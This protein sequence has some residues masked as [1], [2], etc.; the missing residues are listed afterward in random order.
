VTSPSDD[1]PSQPVPFGPFVLDRRLAVG[2]TAEVFLARPKLGTQPAMRFVVKRLLD[3]RRETED[4]LALQHEAEL[5]QAVQHPNVV[6]VYGAGMVGDEPY[7]ALEY[8]EG[9]DLYRFLRRV[10]AEQRQLPAELGVYIARRVAFA[11]EAVHRAVDAQGRPLEIVHRDVTPSNVYLSVDGKVKLGDFGI[12]RVAQQAHG[13]VP[14]GALKGKFGYLA[15]EQIA[16]EPFDGRADLFALGAILGELLI[17]EPVFP[18]SG[19]LA[20]LL[21]I[22]EANLEPLYRARRRLQP[23]LFDICVR[24]LAREPER[25]FQSA[26]ELAEALAPF[27]TGGEAAQSESL[28]QWVSSLSD[29][30]RL[31]QKIQGQIRESVEKMRAV[32]IASGLPPVPTYTEPPPVSNLTGGPASGG[33]GVS[34]ASVVE[35]AASSVRTVDGRMLSSVTFARLVEMVATGELHGDDEVS[36]MGAPLKPLREIDTLARHLLPSTTATTGRLFEPGVPDYHVMLQDTSMLAV[37]ARMRNLRE[38]GGL[39]VELRDPSGLARRKEIY[40]RSG[41]LHHVASSEREELLGEYLVRRG[42]IDRKQLE[43][44]LLELSRTGGRLG[45]TLIAMEVVQAIDVF[46]AIR[47]QGRDRV[48]ALC[49][50]KRGSVAFYRGTQP[51]RVEFP[52][53]LDLA[54]PMMAGV[55]LSTRGRPSSMIPASGAMLTPGPRAEEASHKEERGTVPFSM[56]LVPTL[57]AQGLTIED[58]IRELTKERSQKTAN[59]RPVSPKEAYAALVVARLLGWVNYAAPAS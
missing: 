58:A 22:R 34:S 4:F 59:A 53:D 33:S 27:E 6:R 48:A 24:A 16:G 32:R 20:V 36:L 28:K 30:S 10:E 12:A 49:A 26:A 43:T 9:L 3:S 40:L 45:D 41:R 50:W 35:P 57:A 51:S 46:R 44:A 1:G 18:G 2:G 38:T 5:H 8:V 37:L 13:S 29:S 7:L 52:L 15:P 19:E 39:F 21:A 23:A 42:S 55:I 54:S 14:G 31:A 25:R 11:L 17:G 47:D 56:Q